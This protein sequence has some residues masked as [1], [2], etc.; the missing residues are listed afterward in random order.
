MKFAGQALKGYGAEQRQALLGGAAAMYLTARIANAA[1]NHGD[2]KMDPKDMFSIVV[3]G[4]AFSLRTVQGDILHLATDPNSFILNRLSPMLARP[5]YELLSRRDLYDRRTTALETLGTTAMGATPIAV[6]DALRGGV[7]QLMGENQGAAP[8]F[9]ESIAKSFLQN[10]GVQ[11]RRDY[12]PAE[13]KLKQYAADAAPSGGYSKQTIQAA[14]TRGELMGRLKKANDLK[15]A[16]D[17]AGY[18]KEAS[19]IAGAVRTAKTRGWITDDDIGKV[20]SEWNIDP[21]V[22]SFKDGRLDFDKKLDVW[23]SASKEQ[24]ATLK[25]TMKEAL[26]RE[27]EKHPEQRDEL[28]ARVAKASQ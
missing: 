21:L 19:A 18:Q 26:A 2:A 6:Q 28:L 7:R 27:I 12:S 17:M 23:G 3:G 25:E 16:G 1:L 15:A 9:A 5:L 4:R 13:L 10:F 20:K 14:R 8:G 22:K 24:R 11:M